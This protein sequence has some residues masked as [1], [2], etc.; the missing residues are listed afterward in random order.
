MRLKKRISFIDIAKAI[1]IFSIVICHA[2]V[3]SNHCGKLFTII[4]FFDVPLFF[5]ISG[6]LRKKPE[7]KKVFLI[8]KATRL[9]LPYII[10]SFVFLIPYYIAGKAIGDSI[11]EETSFNLKSSIIAIIWG[12][13][14]DYALKQN[15]PLWFLPALFSTEILFEI[16]LGIF[17]KNNKKI[18]LF[19]AV[20]M[21]AISYFSTKLT[22]TLPLGINSALTLGIFYYAGTLIKEK[23]EYFFNRKNAHLFYAAIAILGLV[24][25][26]LSK[27]PV[28]WIDYNYVNYGY[29]LLIALLISISILYL[30]YKIQKQMILENVGKRTLE[31]LIFHKIP[32]VAAQTMIPIVKHNL[33][34]SNIAIELSLGISISI[35]AIATSML[36]GHI[37]TQ[38]MPQLLGKT[39]ESKK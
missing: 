34:D 28:V 4:S 8:K 31:I 3:H 38:I 19:L 26:S 11:G 20:I 16:L 32:I 1:A 24:M 14:K 10:W 39:K 7:N 12:S 17:K 36:L 2:I 18:K 33:K 6:F 9:M 15:S 30:S 13:G 22:F 29:M 5:I 21:T 27:K 25:A 23:Y 35:I 37:V